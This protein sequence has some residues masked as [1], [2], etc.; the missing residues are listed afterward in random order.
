MAAA[1]QT[2][3]TLAVQQSD[4]A[5]RYYGLGLEA[6]DWITSF[7]VT[8]L[9]ASWGIPYQDQRTWGLDPFYYENGTITAGTGGITAGPRQTL[10]FLIAGHDAGLG[11][12][13]ALDAYLQTKDPRYLNVFN[14][15]YD[16]FQNAQIPSGRA[17][18]PALILST[19]NGHNITLDNGGYWA[20]QSDVSAG[21]DA[22]YGTQDDSAKLHAAFPSPEHG[23][24]IAAALISYYRWAHD[25]SALQ[26]LNRYGNWLV[27]LQ[28]KTGNYTGAF[29]VTQY[30]WN[31]GWKPRMYETTESAW[32]LA[33]LYLL[34]ANVTYLNSAVAAGQ[35]MLSRQ[36]T[37]GEWVNTPV[38]GA[39]PYEWNRT[40]YTTTVS[41][42]HAGFTL[43]AWTQ[44]YRLTGDERYLS[45][46]ETYAKWLMSWQ[47][48][49]ADMA[50]GNHT[51]A[52]DPMA[53]GGYYY[54]YDTEKHK[55]GSDVALSLWSAAYSIRG[56]LFLTETTSDETYA[57]SAGLAADWL[58][59]MRYPDTTLIPLQTLA[60]TKY[61]SSSW[62]GLYPQFYQ[63]D[64][65]E[66][67]KAGI[68]SFVKEGQTNPQAIL[69]LNPTWFERTYS[70]DFNL[71][72]YQM[73]SRGPQF[74][75]MVW[76]WWPNLGFEPRYGADI[77]FGAFT[78]GNYL[79]FDEKF[80]SL[81]ANLMEIERLTSDQ[82]LGL[83]KNITTS[84][85]Q[86]KQLANDAERN[87]NESWYSA[88]MAKVG[89]A[90]ALAQETI[91]ELG[92][93]VPILQTNRTDRTV[94]EGMGTVIAALAIVN[95]YLY[96]A[97]SKRSSQRASQRPRRRR[98]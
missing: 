72:D 2:P 45:A 58:T 24:L 82:T 21:P 9:N 77:A 84:Y 46:A 31:L 98:V 32:I 66:V 78:I 65:G 91:K 86:A 12:S 35:Y 89:D 17:S 56:L 80:Q 37:S 22:R 16:Y 88:A 93:L 18:T 3:P 94:L 57:R 87:F 7:Q 54:G 76:S 48:T 85:Q 83:P 28:I 92:I 39:L 38:Y 55:F 27:K 50:W 81:Q 1:L 44:L 36:F 61:V 70:V 30:Y 15:Y 59:R 71:I 14:V 5:S 73:A 51:Y 13:A 75:K 20:E 97:L 42:N 33:E 74:M 95:V 29:P 43:L 53:V 8:P 11:A 26:L 47:V 6:T 64:M 69:N 25:K 40:K 41:T 68:P 60:I 79:T 62:W 19:I 10:A 67:E 23:N 52:N 96:H 90:S 34:T 4:L 63:P 49:S